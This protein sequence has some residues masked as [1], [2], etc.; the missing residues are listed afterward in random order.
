MISRVVD[1]HVTELSEKKKKPVHLLK[2]ASSSTQR[3]VAGEPREQLAQSFIIVIN[4]TGQTTKM[5]GYTHHS[6][7]Y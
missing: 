3:S 2:E 4:L 1:R 6:E 7:G 5:E